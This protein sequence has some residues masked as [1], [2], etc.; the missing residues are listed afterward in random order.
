MRFGPMQQGNTSENVGP[1]QF[2]T[3]QHAVL[4]VLYRHKGPKSTGGE[5]NVAVNRGLSHTPPHQHSVSNTCA[6]FCHNGGQL[7]N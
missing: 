6:A 5:A 3:L 7:V 4:L 1:L 2:K